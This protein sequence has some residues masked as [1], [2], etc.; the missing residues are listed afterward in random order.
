M[1]PILVITLNAFEY[2]RT[3][4]SLEKNEDLIQLASEKLRKFPVNC[5]KFAEK[6]N[7]FGVS[8]ASQS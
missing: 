4:F 7:G 5:G 6:I 8:T 2:T 1:S 3:P